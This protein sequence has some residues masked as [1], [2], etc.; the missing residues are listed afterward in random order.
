MEKIVCE[1]I[2]K[3]SEEDRNALLDL[4]LKKEK[5][6]N[7]DETAL[8]FGGEAD[9]FITIDGGMVGITVGEKHHAVSGQKLL[10]K[11]QYQG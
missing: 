3:L 11:Y 4:V 6:P 2:E 10:E 7:G 8:Y 1:M 5:N 9:A